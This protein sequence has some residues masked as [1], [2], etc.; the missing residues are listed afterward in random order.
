MPR[1]FEFRDV[2]AELVQALH[3]P[4]AHHAA[5]AMALDAV[6]VFE[7]SGQIGGAEEAE[8]ALEHRAD[9][10]V[11]LEHVDRTF[12]HQLLQPLGERGLAAA[13]GTEQVENLA[14]LFET[15]R[16]VLEV[17]DDP[18]DR[19]FH[20]VEAFE[21]AVA[22]DRAVEEDPRQARVL[23]RVDQLLLADGRDH[24][25]GGRGVKHLVVARGQEPIPQAHGFQLFARIVAVEQVEDIEITHSL[26]LLRAGCL[27]PIQQDV[28]C[29]ACFIAQKRDQCGNV[30]MNT[31][32]TPLFCSVHVPA[33]TGKH[34]KVKHSEGDRVA[35][36]ARPIQRVHRAAPLVPSAR[37]ATTDLPV[38]CIASG[39]ISE[40]LEL[41]ALH[42]NEARDRR[43]P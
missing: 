16:R 41:F 30:L 36:A 25:L 12:L 18:L 31:R 5:Q 27:I 11:R 1:D 17:A 13:D 29:V 14:L 26:R 7:Q 38:K 8:R 35:P 24:A 34:F 32:L 4:R 28:E 15:L 42:G 33:S 43:F 20:A 40:G 39:L 9:P 37:L 23:R 10:I 21:R 19:V 6:F 22:L 3:R 2:A